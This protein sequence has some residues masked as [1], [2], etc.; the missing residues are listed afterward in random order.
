[1]D[2]QA[3][4]E[5]WAEIKHNPATGAIE[6]VRYEWRGGD[7]ARVVEFDSPLRVLSGDHYVPDATEVERGQ[8]V[9]IG[10]Y[11]CRVI[12]VPSLWD[13]SYYVMRDGWRARERWLR[14]AAH[15]RLD[16]IYRRLIVTAAIWGLASY[17]LLQYDG[18]RRP[19]NWTDLYIVQ[20]VRQW[21]EKRRQQ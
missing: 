19:P 10:P 1:M 14:S 5:I 9:A 12:D 20:R 6:Q 3:T 21:R 18:Y 8:V 17:K 7:V 4:G 11:R 13:D 16:L 2:I 15:D